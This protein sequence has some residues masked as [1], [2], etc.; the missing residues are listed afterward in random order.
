M[1]IFITK[2]KYFGA[3]FNVRTL[4]KNNKGGVCKNL[5]YETLIWNSQTIGK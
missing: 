3:V 1:L 5:S 2:R 4:I